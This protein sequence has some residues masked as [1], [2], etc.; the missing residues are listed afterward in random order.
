MN[1]VWFFLDVWLSFGHLN[2]AVDLKNTWLN[3]YRIVVA[4]HF[5]ERLKQL[6]VGFS[7]FIFQNVHKFAHIFSKLNIK[8]NHKLVNFIASK[9]PNDE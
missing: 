9:A 4:Q 8:K 3:A 7:E 5:T 6:C 1:K 2:P